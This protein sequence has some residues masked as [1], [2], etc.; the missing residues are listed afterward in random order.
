[1]PLINCKVELKFKWVKYCIL[2]AASKIIQIQTLIII[3]LLSE[4]MNNIIKIIKSFED[5]I[6]LIDGITE[7][8]KHEIRKQEDRFLP[9]LLAPLGASLVQPVV[10]SVI[11]GMS[12]TVVRRS[13]RRYIDKDFQY[14]SI[15]EAI[16]RLLIISITSLDLMGFFREIIYLK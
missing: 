13:G 16:S 6:L 1:M 11:K 8:V 2:S 10:S 12:R 9:T 7:R 5:S 3:F 14:Y 15:L 4:D